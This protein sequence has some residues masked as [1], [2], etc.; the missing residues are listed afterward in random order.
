MTAGIF[1]LGE[2]GTRGSKAQTL[3]GREKLFLH[4]PCPFQ[5]RVFQVIARLRDLY[6]GK[7]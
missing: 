1:I 2:V 5:I 3:F 4:T 6:A 7:K